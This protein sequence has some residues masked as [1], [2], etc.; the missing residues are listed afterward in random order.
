MYLVINLYTIFN[1]C[2]SKST[3]INCCL[4]T[5]FNIFTYFYTAQMLNFMPTRIGRSIA[6]TV[7]TN[8]RAWMNYRVV[9]NMGAGINWNIVMNNDIITYDTIRVDNCILTNMY[10]VT[11]FSFNGFIRCLICIKKNFWCLCIRKI[12]VINNNKVLCCSNI[13]YKS[14]SGNNGTSFW[15]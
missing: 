11:I 8:N 13:F 10:I 7:W 6:K 4:S 5:N 2:I 12:W 3:P 9:I 15:A 1:N 14:F